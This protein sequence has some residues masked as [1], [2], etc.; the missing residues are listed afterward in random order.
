MLNILRWKN[1]VRKILK[2]SQEEKAS[3]KVKKTGLHGSFHHSSLL[4][5][6]Q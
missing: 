6:I 5:Q 2:L 4:H 3:K 1:S